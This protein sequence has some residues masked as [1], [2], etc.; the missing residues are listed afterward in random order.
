MI[1]KVYICRWCRV[2]YAYDEIVE[3]MKHRVN[4]LPFKIPHTAQR[5]LGCCKGCT[6]TIN[7]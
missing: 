1:V 3:G 2:I 7:E 6:K 4:R 5:K